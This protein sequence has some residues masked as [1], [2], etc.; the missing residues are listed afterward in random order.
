MDWKQL[1]L[2]MRG[3]GVTLATIAKECEFASR[4]HVH[5]ICSG[6]QAGVTWEH[7][8]K[9]RNRLRKRHGLHVTAQRA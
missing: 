1:I 4:G 9:V 7:G 8:E 6:K 3:R 5:D 2:E